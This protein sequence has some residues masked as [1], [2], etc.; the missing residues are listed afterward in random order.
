M[1]GKSLMEIALGLIGDG[2]AFEVRPGLELVKTVLGSAMSKDG[3]DLD[4]L[5]PGEISA[6]VHRGEVAE[7]GFLNPENSPI[8]GD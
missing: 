6:I 5:T 4:A 2:E 1:N 7:D 8:K 3:R